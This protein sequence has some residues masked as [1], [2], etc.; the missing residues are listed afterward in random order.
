MLDRI[1][2]M[3]SEDG[4]Q[5]RAAAV[6]A[7]GCL[8]LYP[9]L[10]DDVSF[11]ADAANSIIYAL[12]DNFHVVRAKA[13][14]S[15][16]NLSGALCTNKENHT[17]DFIQDFS[18]MLLLKLLST[19]TKAAQDNDKVR[20]NAVRAVGNL[21]FYMPERSYGKS[22]F[23]E[24]VH[25]AVDVLAKNV[26]SGPMKVRWNAAYAAGS[27]FRNELLPVGKAHWTETI[28]NALC[29]TIKDCKN[30]KVRINAALAFSLPAKRE[31]YGNSLLFTQ[32]IRCLILGLEAS[33]NVTDF[34]EFRYRDSLLEQVAT[35]LLHMFTLVTPDDLDLLGGVIDEKGNNIQQFLERYSRQML[36]SKDKKI[37]MGKLKN[38]ATHF[39]SLVSLAEADHLTLLNILIQ[40]LPEAEERPSTPEKSAFLDIYD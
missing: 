40:L 1:S 35:S 31:C 20:P 38:A 22:S 36:V 15:L 39:R 24:A 23:S 21:L 29:S 14:W 37:G 18:D 3:M 30:F 16:G 5:V 27:L 2:G 7:L 6:R 12:E 28:H 11:V 4:G 10:R 8:V 32:I 25:K 17:D 19:A 34:A 26:V 9:C 33:E 13:A